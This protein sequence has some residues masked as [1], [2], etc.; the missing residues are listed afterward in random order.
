M[1]V[2]HAVAGVLRPRFAA[3]AVC[4]V[5]VVEHEAGLVL[6]DAGLGTADLADPRRLGP[7][8]RMLRPDPD[9]STTALAAV[10]AL[11]HSATDVTHVVL[12]HLDFDHAGGLSDFPQ[13]VLHTTTTEWAAATVATHA[14]ERLRYRP[15]QWATT[16][17]VRRHAGPGEPWR[18]GLRGHEVLP[19]IT[20]VPLAGH[21]RGHAAVAVEG[22]AGLV[23]HAGDAAFD[24]STFGACDP[25]TG[26]AFGTLPALRAFEA[27]AC[28][29]P[30]RLRRNHAALRRLDADPAVTVVTAHD[31]R[32]LP[33]DAE[34]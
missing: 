4:H 20:L 18:D 32:Q 14:P 30:W 23:V 5:L 17:D 28:R 27:V 25:G 34:V 6:V 7:V 22:D 19:G 8:G 31:P 2:H 33:P 29:Q 13:A 9:P 16:S 21:T 26:D 12:T 24:A 3:R 11:G 1:R 15:V 10:L